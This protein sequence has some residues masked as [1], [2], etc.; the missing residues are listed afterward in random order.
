MTY[1]GWQMGSHYGW[2]VF[3]SRIAEAWLDTAMPMC[4]CTPSAMPSLVLLRWATSVSI[5]QIPIRNTK[6]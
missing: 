5:F 1:I 2:V 4:C 6:E 3:K